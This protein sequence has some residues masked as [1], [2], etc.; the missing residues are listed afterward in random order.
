M[1]DM[2]SFGAMAS[3]T[4]S[5]GGGQDLAR[6]Q[7]E[8]AMEQIRAANKI[9]DGIA[10]QFPAAA[11]EADAVKKALVKVTVKIVGSQAQPQNPQPTGVTG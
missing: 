1:Q 7:M 10:S 8:T 9:I 6:K 11:Q 4:P 3:E 2:Q 5:L